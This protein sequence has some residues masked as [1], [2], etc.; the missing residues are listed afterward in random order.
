MKWLWIAAFFV[1]VASLVLVAFPS[2]KVSKKRLGIEREKVSLSRSMDTF[3]D[4]RG[5]RQALASALNLAGIETEPGLLALRVV[6]ATVVLASLGLLVG[7]VFALLGLVAPVIVTR[8]VVKSK[9]RKRQ[10]AF[11]EQLPDVLQLLITSLRSGHSLPQAFDA[12]VVEASEPARSE[13]ERMLA[14]TRIGVEFHTALRATAQRMASADLEWIASAVEI[15]R[16]AGGNLAEV[17]SNV[18]DTVRGRFRLRRQIKTLT[19]EGRISVKVLTGLPV[20]IFIVR[21]I[22]DS[23]FRDVMFHGSGPLLLAYGA[24]SLTIGWLV[25]SRMI[26]VKGV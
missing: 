9:G 22:I 8:M 24:V 2:R 12:L 13:F 20:F 23:N 4:R 21:S 14:E 7:P 3:L 1:G 17:L 18:N 6:L 16:D 10:E 11:T 15:N 5:K 25:V 19:A 26:R